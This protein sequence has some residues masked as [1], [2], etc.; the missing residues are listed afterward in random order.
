MTNERALLRRIPRDVGGD[1][2]KGKATMTITTFDPVALERLSDLPTEEAVCKAATWLAQLI[3]DDDFLES[4]VL[5]LL[6]QQDGHEEVSVAALADG[7]SAY[8]LLAFRW[9]PG[10][11]TQIH[12]HGSWGVLGVATG[13]L[14]E[15]RFQRLD[16]GDESN[17]VRLRRQ[18]SHDWEPGR[19]SILMPYKGGIHRIQNLSMEGAISI[20]LYGPTLG[21]GGR[22]FDP[23]TDDVDDGH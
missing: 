8:S 13:R 9:S 1:K 6:D 10:S 23:T 20:H 2:L 21:E 4:H 14:H 3:A 19:L 16:D 11:T 7:G 15:E 22:D 12:D 18:W 17:R 5:P